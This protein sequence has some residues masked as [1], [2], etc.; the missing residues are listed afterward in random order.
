MCLLLKIK[1]HI[2]YESLAFCPKCIADDNLFNLSATYTSRSD[3]TSL[4][5]T[6]TGLFW[7]SNPDA[8][9]IRHEN[10]YKSKTF[11]AG[12][13]ISNCWAGYRMQYLNELSKHM[14][15][16]IYGKCGSKK[17]AEKFDCRTYITEKYKFFFA[18]ENSVC[19]GYITEK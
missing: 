3:F 5:W 15:L 18:F 13:L 16:D 2:I 4:Y 7:S 11:L 9:A 12:T 6:D 10:V 19:N 14:P 8:L 17:C 1:V